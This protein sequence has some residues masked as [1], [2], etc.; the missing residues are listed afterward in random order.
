MQPNVRVPE[1]GPTGKNG[2][3]VKAFLG[4]IEF[5]AFEKDVMKPDHFVNR[6]T[7][8]RFLGGRRALGASFA[9]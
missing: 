6:W 7:A 5:L 3:S 9:L 2:L 1:I 4:L 8:G